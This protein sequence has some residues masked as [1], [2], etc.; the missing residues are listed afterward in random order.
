MARIYHGDLERTTFCARL[1]FQDA[2]AAPAHERIPR[3]SEAEGRRSE[4]SEPNLSCD[5]EIDASDHVGRQES[6]E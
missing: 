5:R 4:E 6:V 2:A 1:V 3:R